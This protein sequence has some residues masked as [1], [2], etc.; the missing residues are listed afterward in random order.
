MKKFFFLFIF[1]VSINAYAQT[2]TFFLHPVFYQK[3]VTSDKEAFYVLTPS[4]KYYENSRNNITLNI[5]CSLIENQESDIKMLCN[6]CLN[7]ECT[8]H[9]NTNH[10]FSLTKDQ[11]TP[12][13]YIINHKIYDNLGNI[14]FEEILTNDGLITIP[15][16]Q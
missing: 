13:Q 12:E 2:K 6:E 16:Y 8:S 4:S 1:V 9:T 5:P 11:T 15:P 14:I 10:S 3:L 7:L